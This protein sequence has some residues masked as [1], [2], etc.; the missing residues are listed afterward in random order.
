MLG[1]RNLGGGSWSGP[2]RRFD[3]SNP[4]CSFRLF[5]SHITNLS[6][7]SYTILVASNTKGLVFDKLRFNLKIENMVEENS[8]E[9]AG[10]QLNW[11]ADGMGTY[12]DAGTPE[13]DV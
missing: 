3:G 5:S 2:K 9:Q 13:V 11:P 7:R 6:E 4:Y 8:A 12:V 10:G 1:L